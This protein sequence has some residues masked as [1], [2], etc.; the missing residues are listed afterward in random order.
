MKQITLAID[1]PVGL[2]FIIDNENNPG[3][4]QTNY[5]FVNAATLTYDYVNVYVNDN[6][7]FEEQVKLSYGADKW[8]K[9]T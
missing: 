8:L 9:P 1:D 2:K 7:N 6:E 5:D 4:V 3:V